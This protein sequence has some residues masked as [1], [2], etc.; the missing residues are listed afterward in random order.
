MRALSFQLFS[1]QLASQSQSSPDGDPT[2]SGRIRPNPLKPEAEVGADEPMPHCR[3]AAHAAEKSEA[4]TGE[5]DWPD[6]QFTTDVRRVWRKRPR[7]A[8]RA[9][10][11]HRNAK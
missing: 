5:K 8:R 1:L 10:R 6:Q 11:A 7:A 4:R 2:R 3:V 9:H